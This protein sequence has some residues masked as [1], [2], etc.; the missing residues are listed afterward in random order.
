MKMEFTRFAAL[1]VFVPMI[2]L[3][4][5]TAIHEA[6]HTI[7]SIPESKCVLSTASN[8]Q[9]LTVRGKA[10][11][12]AHDLV[13]DIPGCDETVLLT[14]AG[15]QDNNVSSTAL[16]Q[17][18]ELKRFQKYIISVYMNRGENNCIDCR[19]YDDVEAELT[20]KL[21]IA[22]LPPGATRDKVNFM[23]DGSGKVIGTFGWGH[24][25]PFASYRLIIQSVADVKAKKLPPP[26]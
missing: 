1:C 9:T 11:H 18:G 19:M 20:G 14:Y 26:K 6:R 25:G 10:R 23:R 8:E 21:E 7:A 22:T 2:A 4:Q 15:N 5:N 13:F 12:T 17:D 16:R 24:P 3:G